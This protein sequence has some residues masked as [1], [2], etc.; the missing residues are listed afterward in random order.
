MRLVAARPVHRSHRDVAPYPSDFEG[1]LGEIQDEPVF[2]AGG[3]EV[4][5]DDGKVYALELLD[6]LELDD[7]LV[8]DEDV[9][10]MNTDLD[11][12]ED[13]RDLGFLV[14]LDASLVE[15]DTQAVV[16]DALEKARAESLV[17]VNGSADDVVRGGNLAVTRLLG[18]VLDLADHALAP[19]PDG[20]SGRLTRQPR[21]TLGLSGTESESIR[22]SNRFSS[23]L[24]GSQLVLYGL[25]DSN[26]LWKV[27]LSEIDEWVHAGGAGPDESST[28]D[29]VER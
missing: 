16:I 10:A 26:R 17:H 24:V 21:T 2:D 9:E 13:D 18:D 19:F 22:L 28:K 11:I 8:G 5:T 12:V 27:K 4:G 20:R 29:E 3:P 6:R 1:R 23:T 15:N 7:Q 25:I 14:E